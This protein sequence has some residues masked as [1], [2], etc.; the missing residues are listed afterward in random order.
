MTERT[1]RIAGGSAFWGDSGS[2]IGQLLAVPNLDY[3]M[4]EYLAEITMALLA[5]ARAKSDTA[6]FVPDFV[7]AITPHLATIKQ[8]GIKLVTNAGGTNP[9]AC[10]QAL[11]KA[12]EAQ[13]ITLRIAVVEGDDL[14]GR[15]E[16]F[17]AAGI[18]DW[19]SGA[20]LP[21]ADRL[22]SMNAYLGATPVAEALGQGAEVVITGRNVDSALVLG[23]LMHEFGW[24]PDDYDRLAA[25]SLCGHL[26]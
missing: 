10:A 20:P 19:R 3:L 4:L 7:T 6:G 14:V 16:D 13:G 2:A 18:G 11:R 12:A 5:R 22:L 23:P 21:P 17:R 26:I 9:V 25:G 8:R 15:A 1:I 24:R